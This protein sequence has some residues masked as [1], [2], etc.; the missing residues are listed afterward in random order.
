[1]RA[2]MIVAALA[3]GTSAAAAQDYPNKPI[4]IV[5]PAAAG[6]PTD[7]ISRVT[8]QSMSRLLGQ[9]IVI[10]NVGGAGGTIGTARVVR[11]APDGYTLLIYHVGLSTAATL[12][13]QLPYDTRRAFAPIGLITDAPMTII[14]RSNYPPKTLKEFVDYIKGQG[15]K[16]TMGNAGVGS[17]SHLCGMLFMSETKLQLTTVPYRGT[18]PVMNDLVGKQIDASCDQATNTTGPI[19]GNTVKAYAVTTKVRLKSLPD[20]PTADEAGLKG[21]ELGVWHGLF[22]PAGTPPAIVDRLSVALKAALQDP[23]LIKRFNDISTEPVIEARA[24]PQAA[25]RTLLSEI[26]R[27]APIIKAAGQYAD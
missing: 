10:E 21:F 17:A 13:R 23:E 16:T 4:T 9:Q 25:E 19:L 24:T 27:W 5:V 1:M 2:L 3:L 15:G 22:A 14:A 18:G 12:Y 20:V 7:T 8:A 26:D 6:G 11:A